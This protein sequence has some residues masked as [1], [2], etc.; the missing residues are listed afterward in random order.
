MPD[1]L[2]QKTV[3][4]VS[5]SF[6]EQILA[7]GVNFV[8]GIILARLLT[9]TDYGLVGMLGFFIA[10]SQLFIDGG[11]AG[12]LIRTKS[13]S[14]RDYS[15]VYL[16]N[17]T[18]SIAF[19]ILLFSI[20]PFVARYY[21][22]PI[23]KSMLRVIA[24]VLVISSLSS[25][26]GILLSIR[27]DFKTKTY[28]SI[29]TSVISGVL[30]IIC[31][32]KGL[33]VWALVTQTLAASTVCTIATLV[34]VRWMPR[35]FFSRESF[36][37]LFSY[38]SKMLA[39]ST[40]SVIY[41]NLY[42]L[43]IGKRFTAADVGQYTRAGQFP[44]IT[45]GTITG[46]LNR[47]A[48]PILSQIQDDDERLLRVY[49]KYIQLACFL[50]FPA[51][52]GLCGCA[53]PLI[54]FL[55]TDKW[56]DCVPL[57]QIICFGLLTNAITT[58]N[59]NLLYVKGRSDLVLKLE[60]IKKSIAFAILF[61]TMFFNIKVMCIGQ[62][63]YGF[64]AL[65][66]NTHYSKKILRYGFKPQIK[67]V[68]PYFLISLIILAEA[69]LSSYLIQNSPVSLIVSLTVCPFTYWFIAKTAHLY[70]Y[71]EARELIT[72]ILRQKTNRS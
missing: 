8:I 67:S 69:L 64:I 14:D 18:L 16:I 46:A 51:L 36:K 55:L 56:L 21:D 4:G 58:I 42:P 11:L 17:L 15:T 7:R 32:Y 20:A 62:A 59:L 26:Q 63:I 35:L 50:I 53:K 60:I 44:G 40:I 41:D 66:L 34:F 3:T 54:I 27:V 68:T 1:D 10:I 13:P 49:E 38:S 61:I 70:A 19:Y 9:P 22:Q 48:F 5:W 33:G 47:V 23:L 24:L 12:A 43:V 71:Q 72:D 52:M 25:V 29:L 30:G 28:I 31:A 2:K 57:M 37:R 6:V 45:N 65:F 39:A